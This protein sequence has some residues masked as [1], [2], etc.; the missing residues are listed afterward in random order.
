MVQVSENSNKKTKRREKRTKIDPNLAEHITLDH[1][2]VAFFLHPKKFIENKPINRFEM[3]VAYVDLYV[4]RGNWAVNHS[5]SK[6]QRNI[7][8]RVDGFKSLR[9]T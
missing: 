6:A 5:H 4:L 2:Y 9:H 8:F 7:N 3:W 1:G